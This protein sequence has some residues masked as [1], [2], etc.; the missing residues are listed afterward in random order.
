MDAAVRQGKMTVAEMSKRTGIS[1]MQL[2]DYLKGKE[3]TEG[4]LLLSVLSIMG[5]LEIP[6]ERLFGEERKAPASVRSA[7]ATLQDWVEGR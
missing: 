1:R 6:P 7:M 3:S 2:Y 5:A 4:P